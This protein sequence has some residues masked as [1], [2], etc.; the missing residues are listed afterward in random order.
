M[1]R[2]QPGIETRKRILT[3][4]RHLLGEAGMEGTTLKA[5]CD[6]ADIQPGSFYNLFAS[7]EEAILSVVRE[8]VTA[9]DPDPDHRGT[10]TVADLVEAYVAFVTDQPV[11]AKVY[12]K[13]AVGGGMSDDHLT[14]R[15]LVHH[16]RRIE[17]FTEALLREYPDLSDMD[18]RRSAE[19][20]LATLNGLVLQ[21]SLD[22]ETDVAGQARALVATV[23][24]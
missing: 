6:R 19:R 7:K 10:D 18:A 3:A 20:I 13:M 4:V 14:D 23:R 8:A 2:Y 15:V 22:P 21:W 17:R 16:R 5:I 11:L 1:A 12:L 9:V 24:T